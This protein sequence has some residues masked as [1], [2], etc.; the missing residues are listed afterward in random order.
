MVELRWL[1]VGLGGCGVEMV[2][3]GVEGVD[4]RVECRWWG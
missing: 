3:D 1:V 2:G 4:G